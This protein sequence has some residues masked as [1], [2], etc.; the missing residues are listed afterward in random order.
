MES[1]DPCAGPDLTE[2]ITRF[3]SLDKC[4]PCRQ[5][6][7]IIHLPVPEREPAAKLQYDLEW[8]SVLRKTHNLTKTHDR[9]VEMP[10]IVPI[11]PEDVDWVRQRF[12]KSPVIPE[13]FVRTVPAHAG[14]PA[15]LPR[16]LPPAFSMMGNP[17]TDQLLALLQLSHVTTIPYSGPCLA[18]DANEIA[19]NEGNAA[20]GD[21]N[22][23]EIDSDAIDNTETNEIELNDDEEADDDVIGDIQTKKLRVNSS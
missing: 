11:T 23:I 19:C 14:P 10:A 1:S 9:K 21:D 8:L 22:E 15:P 5:Y 3:L 2:Q 16:P 17:Q 20:V 18:N 4:L 12:G 13:N 6:L 7:S